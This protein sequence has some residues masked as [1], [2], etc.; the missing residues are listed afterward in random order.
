MFKK[1]CAILLSCILMFSLVACGGQSDN[2]TDVESNNSD[3]SKDKKDDSEKKS[4]ANINAEG[5]P[6]VDEPI[7][8]TMMA[9][10]VGQHEWENM[11]FFDEM[12]ERTNVKIEFQ[13]VPSDSLDTKKNLVFASG[14][15]PDVFFACQLT[16]QEEINYGAQGLLVSLEELIDEYAVNIKSVF[17]KDENIRKGV[18]TLDGHIYSIPYVS[19][20]GRG[21]YSSPLWYN[22]YW[23]EEL[24]VT[25]L[26]STIDELYDLLVRFKNED[27]NGNGETDEIPVS[28][29]MELEDLEPYL[30][31][32][33]GHHV[34]DIEV[35]DDVV[36]Y[37]PMEEGFKGYLEFMNRLW[38]GELLDHES[39]T[40]TQDQMKSKGSN[41]QI[42]LFMNWFSYFV[43]GEDE[44][45]TK[46]PMF[47]PLTSE[48][49]DTP[50][51]NVGINY[52]SGTYAISSSNAHP[53]ASIRW[54]DYL[55]GV[56]GGT[57]LQLG[58]EGVLWEY[59][60][61]DSKTKIRLDAP[62]GGD[63]E[64]YRGK[65]TPAY[66]IVAPGIDLPEIYLFE[67]ED[68]TFE[69]FVDKET[70]E[71]IKPYGSV[72]FPSVYFTVEETEE[73]NQ[74]RSD[75]D[76][77]MKEMKAAFVTGER[78]L[79]EW[80]S[81]IETLKDLGAERLVEIYKGAYDRWKA[82]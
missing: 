66:G 36:R 50:M 72:P 46:H 5:L 39:F 16:K 45:T 41:N 67:E 52:T 3:V 1:I 40:Q 11:D 19:M 55:Y 18:T 14:D 24:G 15:L 82:N 7:T 77:Y 51:T 76:T 10:D 63:W 23:L 73:I 12:E 56:E 2:D 34:A 22:G 4:D 47:Q 13:T 59:K 70:D 30:L 80:D 62:D 60:D 29:F 17:E 27:P 78:S 43:T 38:N 8:L 33:F 48:Y 44:P 61:E 35:V 9:P 31:G 75:L 71:K 57:L 68:T 42:G 28:S 53:E 25:E 49:N 26:P 79:S 64:D 32:A 74:I 6:I 37:T 21:W 81:Y 69:D 20:Y 54:I 65:V 58:K